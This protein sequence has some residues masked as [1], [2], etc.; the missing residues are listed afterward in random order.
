MTRPSVTAQA[1]GTPGVALLLFAGYAAIGWGWYAY[2][3]NFLLVVAA[4]FAARRTLSAVDEVR[5]Y[6]DW[7]QQLARMTGS[8]A[9][10]PVPR[11]RKPVVM[12][13]SVIIGT[14]ALENPAPIRF[15]PEL[16]RDHSSV[17]RILFGLC[18]WA[19][20]YVAFALLGMLVSGVRRLLIK[21]HAPVAEKVIAAA[22]VA[23]LLD[24]ASASPSRAEATAQLPDYC[25]ALL[26][27]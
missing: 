3:L 26:K 24:R 1:M 4:I 25:A 12:A 13:L 16:A 18:A 23:W 19:C 21:P 7:Q 11:R 9:A 27:R 8:D 14:A 17:R 15:L 22:P 20:A 2:H 5:R 10:T 6:K